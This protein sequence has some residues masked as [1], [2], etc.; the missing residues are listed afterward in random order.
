[1]NFKRGQQKGQASFAE[2]K[3]PNKP[4][5]TEPGDNK[6]SCL[7]EPKKEID[8]TDKELYR[9]ASH[10][11]VAND[12]KVEGALEESTRALVNV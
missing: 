6:M 4:Y 5:G 7:T 8:A 1:M 3:P 11:I 9:K 2:T 10:I 12:G